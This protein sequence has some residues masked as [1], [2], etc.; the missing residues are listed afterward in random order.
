MDYEICDNMPMHKRI[1]QKIKKICK[2]GKPGWIICDESENELTACFTKD[3]G[4]INDYLD[5]ANSH[6]PSNRKQSHSISVGIRPSKMITL[7]FWGNY[8]AIKTYK[9]INSVNLYLSL[10]KNEYTIRCSGVRDIAI[11]MYPDG[12]VMTARPNFDRKYYP[13]TVKNVIQR[14]PS[15]IQEAL[16]EEFAENSLLYKDFIADEFMATMKITDLN[17]K[18]NKID[19]FQSIFP[20]I[21]FPKI[22][23]K[24]DCYELY[25]IGCAAK[26]VEPEQVKLLFE[27]EYLTNEMQ[28]FLP[29][30]RNCKEIGRIYV[31]NILE[32][33]IV[34]DDSCSYEFNFLIYDYVEMAMELKEKIDIKVGKKKIR[35]LHDEYA[36]RLLKKKHR[37]KIKIPETPLKHLKLSKEFILL[38]TP[39][40]LYQEQKRQ[41]NCVS[42]YIGRIENGSCIIYSADINGE[43][44]TIEIRCRKTRGKYTFIVPQCL[45]MWN[46][47]CSKETLEYV[48]EQVKKVGEQAVKK[49]EKKIERKAKNQ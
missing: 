5:F 34:N 41:H 36:E 25:A 10:N 42:S 13:T 35:R 4:L 2:S 27:R 47:Y 1:F 9:D 23:N 46:E 24:M 26:Y 38:D 11:L 12:A 30:K 49:Y 8:L 7:T 31:Q 40:A 33:R 22:A 37:G 15:D 39:G 3:I 17:K 18:F 28:T 14:L 32:Q 29:S 6:I 48:K 44:V 20:D 45:K 19:Y 16:F 21:T 43:H